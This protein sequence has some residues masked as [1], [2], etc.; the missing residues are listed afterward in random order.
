MAD[1]RIINARLKFSPT[2]AGRDMDQGELAEWLR[3]LLEF[4]NGLDVEAVVNRDPMPVMLTALRRVEVVCEDAV[5]DAEQ[6]GEPDN[7]AAAQEAWDMV[8][9]AIAMSEGN[10]DV[11]P[12]RS[13]QIKQALALALQALD[14]SA[15]DLTSAPHRT[16]GHAIAISEVHRALKAMS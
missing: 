12:P 3:S 5:H 10:A 8:G 2:E 6:A 13:E 9:A 16:A 15:G 1:S 11:P 14:L 4:A 7:A